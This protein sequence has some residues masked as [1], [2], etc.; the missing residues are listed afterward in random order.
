MTMASNESYVVVT[1]QPWWKRE[2]VLITDARAFAL[3][4]K[5]PVDIHHQPT[6]CVVWV[7]E[8]RPSR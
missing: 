4:Q 8:E 7:W 2:F 6:G 5:E 3:S 1:R